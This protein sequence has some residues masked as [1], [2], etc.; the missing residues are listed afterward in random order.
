MKTLTTVL[1][2]ILLSAIVFFGSNGCT[3]TETDTV[4]PVI[5]MSSVNA[6]PHDCDTLRIGE[7]F[8]FRG[9]FTD[10]AELGSYSLDIHNNFDHHSHS[11][12]IVECPLDPIKV[13][14]NPLTFIRDYP[15]PDGSTR[16]EAIDT[17]AIPKGVDAGD[18]HLM[19]RVTDREGWQSVKGIS[20][21]IIAE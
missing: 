8:V 20:V 2:V 10:N 19:I 1:P 14:V 4:Y 17:I 7:S 6:F 15:I 5:D 9:I 11:S 13:P 12:S 18:Y 16:Y 21:K 3:K